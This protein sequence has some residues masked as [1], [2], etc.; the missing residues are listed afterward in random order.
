MSS[1]FTQTSSPRRFKAY[2]VSLIFHAA[3]FVCGGLAL[4]KPAQFAVEAGSG[5]IEVNL[6]AAPA[7]TQTNV[8]APDEIVMPEP[9]S[10]PIAKEVIEE[11]QPIIPAI[12]GD[13]SSTV[14]GQD[15]TTLQSTGGAVTD[16]KPNYLRN[17]A[18]PYPLEARKKK[19]E[20]LVVLKVDVSSSGRVDAIKIDTASGH[21]LLDDTAIRTVRKWHFLPAKLGAVSVSSEVL[22]PVRFDLTSGDL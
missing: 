6:V 10:K 12:K 16:A 13:G 4:M 9:E 1:Y 21:V 11:P 14:P 8:I 3:L 20:G 22:V 18:P 19:W 2:L 17:P 7:E 5:G 15:E